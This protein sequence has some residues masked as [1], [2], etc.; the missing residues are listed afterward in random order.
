[1]HPDD[2]DDLFH[3]VTLG[4]QG[5][6]V[7]EPVL[8]AFD[9]VDVFV[10]VHGDPYN[11]AP[12]PLW[13]ALE[14]ID[15]LGFGNGSTSMRSGPSRARGRG[16]GRPGHCSVRSSALGQMA[17]PHRLKDFPVRR[18]SAAWAGE[19]PGP[20]TSRTGHALGDTAKQDA[21]E[22]RSPVGSDDNRIR[23]PVG[24][25]VEDGLP[26]ASFDHARAHPELRLL[27]T[28]HRAMDQRAG[29]PPDVF[30]SRQDAIRRPRSFGERQ[31]R[32]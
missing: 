27:Q 20:G 22:P 30:V 29:P 10:E 5:R 17:Q 1:M 19:R 13:R 32:G 11:R 16:P 18:R 31:G 14:L 6:I 9:G 3:R 12:N 26:R 2:I 25:H 21:V 23:R 28:G 4:S 24:S 15:Q 8:V 7:Y